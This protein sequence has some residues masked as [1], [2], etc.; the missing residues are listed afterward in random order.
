MS[1]LII[2]EAGVNHN[3]DL[4]MAFELIDAAV[5]AG[6]DAVKF[7]TFKAE[8]LATV[9][10]EKAG[11]QKRTSG[12]A[13]S[14]FAMLKK[15]EL[16]FEDHY[17]LS[18]YCQKKN[19]RFLSTAFDSESLHF[20]VDKMGVGT[21]K[22]PSGDITNA[23]LL[24]EHARYKKNMLVSTGMTDLQ[25]VR[26]ALEVIAF[27]MI[28]D[29]KATPSSGAF[30]K[31][32]LTP[33]GQS[34][35]R[36][37]VTLLHCTTEYPAPL[38]DINLRA[39]VTMEREFGLPVGYSDHSEGITVPVAAAAC[40][41]TVVEKHFTL[42]RTLEGPDHKASL[43]PA[44]LQQ[45]VRAIR[46]VELAQGDGIKQARPSEL[47]NRDI[48]RKSLVASRSIAKGEM[49][50]TDNIS[51]K[52]PGNGISPVHLWDVLGKKSTQNFQP[53]DLLEI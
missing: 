35:L 23:P 4:S 30:K 43:E 21:L 33:E 39:M 51:S 31:A 19:I 46:D 28:S 49:F 22:I 13:E 6:A 2:A 5:E 24:L 32:F 45:M 41:A 48:T 53:D 12:A 37:T 17:K 25:D 11:Y 20:L 9:N 27:G 34:L 38:K 14:Q 52:R 47:A 44:Q 16:P 50:S 40:G 18:S 7:Q 26:Q 10:V 8:K 15:L 36:K 1:V 42:D 3:G 29:A